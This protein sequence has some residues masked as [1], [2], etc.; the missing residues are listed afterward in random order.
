MTEQQFN[1]IVDAAAA[2]VI[3]AYN[4]L[5]KAKKACVTPQGP[6]WLHDLLGEQI[7]AADDLYSNE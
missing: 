6:A 3:D 4:E 5:C 2:S 1:A 7:E